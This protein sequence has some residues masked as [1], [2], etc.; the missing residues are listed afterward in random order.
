MPKVLAGIFTKPA[1]ASVS[2]SVSESASV[3]AS[4]SVSVSVYA[5]VSASAGLGVLAVRGVAGV[6][7]QGGKGKGGEEN[8]VQRG[9]LRCG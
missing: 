9:T 1:P 2:E 6:Q 3:S 4:V 5:S 8:G 7:A